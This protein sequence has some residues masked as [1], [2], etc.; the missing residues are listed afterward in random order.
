MSPWVL[1]RSR[2]R[3]TEI[4]YSV[5]RIVHINVFS[6]Y[7]LTTIPILQTEIRNEAYII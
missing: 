1:L 3:M 6:V 7:V 4:Y 5:I 2:Q